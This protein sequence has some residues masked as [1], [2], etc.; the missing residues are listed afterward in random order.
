MSYITIHQWREVGYH[1][2]QGLLAAGAIKTPTDPDMWVAVTN[3]A[4]YCVG[5]IYCQ[6]NESAWKRSL[7]KRQSS[8]CCQ[9]LYNFYIHQCNLLQF[10]VIYHCIYSI[11]P[12]DSGSRQIKCVVSVF[13]FAVWKTN[14]CI[15]SDTKKLLFWGPHGSLSQCIINDDVQW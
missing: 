8:Y 4:A 2:L 5:V 1:S 12:C 13:V 6:N 10:K 7:K 15:C 3:W 11:Y 9:H 14:Q